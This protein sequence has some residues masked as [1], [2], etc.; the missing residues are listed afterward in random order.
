MLLQKHCAGKLNDQ[1]KSFWPISLISPAAKI[2]EALLLPT[3]SNAVPHADY[4]QLVNCTILVA[5]DLTKAFDTVRHLKFK[6]ECVHQML[7]LCLPERSPDL[8]WISWIKVKIQKYYSGCPAI[9]TLFNL[10]MTSMPT[11]LA[12]IIIKTYAEDATVYSSGPKVEP[13]C[14]ELN[15]YLSTLDDWFKGRNLFLSSSKYSA[16]IFSTFNHEMNTELPIFIKE[17]AVLTDKNPKIL[18]LTFDALFIFGK[19]IEITKQKMNQRINILKAISCT[20][21]GP[22]KELLTNTYKAISQS[23]ATYACPIWSP[24]VSKTNWDKIQTAQN[25]GLRC[26]TWNVKMASKDNLHS[27]LLYILTIK[28]HNEMISEQFFC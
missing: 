11:L 26:A 23:L 4:Q 1:N 19:H 28:E 17:E 16:S 7:A 9:P 3:I 6:P 8:R 10:Y 24:S 25:L 20:D 2:L 18:G 27:E 22:E 15:S 13:I 21:W 5:I 12:T 14:K